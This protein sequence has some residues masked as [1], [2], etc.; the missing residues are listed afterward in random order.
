MN[1]SPNDCLLYYKLHFSLLLYVKNKLDLFKN[2]TLD[3]WKELQTQLMQ[4][5]KLKIRDAL[6]KNMHL[7]EMFV[8][9]NPYKFSSEEMAIITGWKHLLRDNFYVVRYLK[10]YA[11]FLDTN[12][13]ARAYGVR[14]LMSK[15]AEVIPYPLPVM[16]NAVLL[17]FKEQI[18]YD[19]L[20][21]PYSIMF[22]RGITRDIND[23]YQEAKA[24]YGIITSLA[25]SGQ[26]RKVDEE[27]KLKFYLKN[28]RNREYY[29]EEVWSLL[30]KHPE[31]LSTYHQEMGKS[32]S[33]AYGKRLR[34]AGISSGYFAILEG[35]IVASG[36]KQKDVEKMLGRLLPV[37]K[38][39]FVY[40]FHLK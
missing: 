6:Y 7:I 35:M 17:P 23:T 20:L 3:T 13:P 10:E 28:E 38:R 31:M 40:I 4:E 8:N 27:E 14:G 37:E 32:Y 39:K 33:R 9:E 19:G 15:F 25:A 18:I 26:Q 21:F 5:Q 1:L 29:R 2:I 24:A 16:T 12:T 22:G 30:E 11:V 34:E 36:E